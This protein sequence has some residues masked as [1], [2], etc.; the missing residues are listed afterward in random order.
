M[1][2]LLIDG[3]WKEWHGSLTALLLNM[4]WMQDDGN[5]VIHGFK[6]PANVTY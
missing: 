3:I 5:T 4:G 6:L 2:L 1:T